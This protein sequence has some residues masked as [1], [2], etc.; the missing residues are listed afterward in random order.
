MKTCS[1]IKV[2][3]IGA[4]AVFA[5][6]LMPQTSYAGSRDCD[7]DDNT[8]AAIVAGIA[9]VGLIA[10]IASQHSN[11]SVDYS[12]SNRVY[13]PPQCAPPPPPPRCEPPQRW[14]PG[15]YETVREKVV[16][17]GYWDT[18]TTPAEYAWVKHGCRW[19]YTMIKP[20][21]TKRVWVPERC[22]WI[23]KQVWVAGHYEPV[24]RP[25]TAHR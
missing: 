8:G 1:W 11:V 13:R 22:E 4:A 25:Y 17:P 3:A 6:T 24:P 21:C 20:P 14:I 19:E 12:Y 5:T 16:H 15:H 10:A 7:N 9:A 2:S 18:V 23:E